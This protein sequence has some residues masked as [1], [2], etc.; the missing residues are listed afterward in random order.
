MLGSCRSGLHHFTSN[1]KANVT[2]HNN[3]IIF[4]LKHLHL[5]FFKCLKWDKICRSSVWAGDY[6]FYKNWWSSASPSNSAAPQGKEIA[7]SCWSNNSCSEI[8]Y[9]CAGGSGWDGGSTQAE[10]LNPL[11]CALKEA[12]VHTLVCWVAALWCWLQGWQWIRWSLGKVAKCTVCVDLIRSLE[13]LCFTLYPI[14]EAQV[15][16]QPEAESLCVPLY[17]GGCPSAL[18]TPTYTRLTWIRAGLHRW[19]SSVDQHISE[20]GLWVRRHDG[21]NN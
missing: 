11:L 5:S 15:S 1:F 14:C 18:C 3:D 13:G 17:V 10:L 7:K 12:P 4:D 2:K 19:V 21:W 9:V 8:Q 6:D 20:A 16:A